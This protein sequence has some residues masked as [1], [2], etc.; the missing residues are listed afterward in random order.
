[1]PRLTTLPARK[2]SHP[3]PDQGQAIGLEQFFG[4][5]L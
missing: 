4:V 2:I 5:T 3:W 1:L